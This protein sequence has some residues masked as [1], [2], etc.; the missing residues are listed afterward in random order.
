MIDFL[1]FS[2]QVP[3]V[4]AER[5][6]KLAP[7]VAARQACRPRPM[8]C[9]IFLKA[10]ALVSARV[11]ELRRAYLPLPWP[12]LYEHPRSIGAFS[13]ARRIDDEEVVVFGKCLRVDKDSVLKISDY[14]RRCQDEPIEQINTYRRFRL[15]AR[16]P[17][18]IRRLLWQIGLN[19]SGNLRARTFGTFGITS[20]GSLGAAAVQ[21]LSVTTSTLLYGLFEDDGSLVVRLQLDHRVYD[22]I[23]AARALVELE[24]TLLTE[25]FAEVQ[26]MVQREAA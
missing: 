11:P 6:M 26:S 12:R 23:V 19:L 1:H 7:L 18:I 9:A 5:R 8:W 15:L 14:M 25:I 4:I 21:A 17:R 24:R 3:A 22:G 13:V 10:F 20:I 16:F 2:Q